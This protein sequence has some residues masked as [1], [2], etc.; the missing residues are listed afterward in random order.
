M[1]VRVWKLDQILQLGAFAENH[2]QLT[3]TIQL[4]GNKQDFSCFSWKLDLIL[5]KTGLLRP[6][7]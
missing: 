1:Q 7:T 2:D 4:P 3:E 5:N 6:Y